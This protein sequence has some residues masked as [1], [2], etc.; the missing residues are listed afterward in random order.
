VSLAILH[1]RAVSGSSAPAVTVECHLANGL[2][3]FTIVGLAEAE[4]RES[5]DRVR[6]ALVHSGFEFPMRRITVNLAPADLPKHSGRFD[7]PIALG[8]LAASGLL[9]CD[10]LSN[11]ESVGELSLTGAL[12][13]VRGVLAMAL[14][15]QNDHRKQSLPT[16]KKRTLIVPADN[17]KEASLARGTR[18]VAAQSLHEVIRILREGVADNEYIAGHTVG[19]TVVAAG[20]E[21]A[22][23]RG[24]SM[25]KRALEL[26]AAGQH[27]LLMC[28]PPGSGKSMLAQCMPSIMPTMTDDE[29]L[30]SAAA[31]G[32]YGEFDV[33]RWKQRPF[34]NPHHTASAAALIGGSSNP[35]PGE[36]SLSHH[37]ILFL[38]EVPEF[39]RHVIEVLREPM[40]TG[41]VTIARANRRS[42]FPARFQL[43]G[44]MNP[45]PCGYWG[46]TRCRCTG[47][48]VQRYQSRLSGPFLDRIDLQVMVQAVKPNELA[49]KG[50]HEP[51]SEQTSQT[52]QARVQSARDRQLKR[53]GKPN[54]LLTVSEIDQ[55]LNIDTK[56]ANLAG[57]AMA[58]MSWSARTF[59]RV[60]RLSRSIADLEDRLTVNESD[61]AQAIQF[62]PRWLQP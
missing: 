19:Q 52:V 46:Q 10:G 11:I 62:R 45:C 50:N 37:G 53:Q 34:R 20:N 35:K 41:Q 36:A 25:A 58:K 9:K 56:A 32:L 33:S 49:L 7:L 27:H 54:A 57:Q 16:D 38:D 2:P 51:N 44:A 48:Q 18:V 43:I 12:R 26:A 23:V 47:D 42:E 15:C 13:P 39:S 31:Q 3:S 61:V 5:R 17:A 24:Q 30:E 59:H 21:L 14:A 1:S 60:L 55:C 8:I 29:A 28:G 40:E 6:A 4:V 22:E